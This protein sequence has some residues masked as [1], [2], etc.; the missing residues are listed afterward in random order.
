MIRYVLAVL[1][2]VTPALAQDTGLAVWGKIHEVFSHPAARIVMSA[3]T[4]CRSGLDPATAP[5][6]VRTG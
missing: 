1:F 6:P 2:V 5:R 3:P 4:T